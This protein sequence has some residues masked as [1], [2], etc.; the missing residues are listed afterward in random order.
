MTHLHTDHAGGLH[1]FPG[2]E[3]LVSRTEYSAASGFRGRI[4][5]YPN[6]RWP[7]WFAPHLLDF[8]D[9]PYGPFARSLL[10]TRAG[11]V[12]L[13]ATPGHTAGHLSVVVQDG[14]H[15]VF[16]A[17]DTSYTQD[18]LIE[19]APDGVGP[20]EAQERDTHRRIL[21]LAR[22]APTIYLPAHD[23]ASAER[24][25]ERRALSTTAAE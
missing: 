18:L 19:Q 11:D 3:I 5:G 22:S 9:R 21:Q 20:D 4:E 13:V 12:V 17:G 7:D 2:V 14:D 8:E 1:H 15:T 10:L 24:L 23:P 6:T 25:A 16:L